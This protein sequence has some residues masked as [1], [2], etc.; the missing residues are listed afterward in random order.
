MTIIGKQSIGLGGVLFLAAIGLAACTGSGIKETFSLAWSDSKGGVHVQYSEDGAAW[1]NAA[2]P[3][4]FKTVVGVGVAADPVGAEYLLIGQAQNG[5]RVG[6]FSLGP[7]GYMIRPPDVLAN[8]SVGLMDT[9]PAMSSSSLER[10]YLAYRSVENV[11]VAYLERV[12]EGEVGSTKWKN[13][14]KDETPLLNV[15]NTAVQGWPSLSIKGTRVVVSWFRKPAGGTGELQI[16]IGDLQPNGSIKWLGGQVFPNSEPN[17]GGVELEH[18]LCNDGQHFFLGVTR[19]DGGAQVGQYGLY[20]YKSVDG[21]KWTLNQYVGMK[22]PTV[23]ES[24][25]N[26]SPLGI[27]V[28]SKGVIVVAEY[29]GGVSRVWRFDKQWSKSSSKV[30]SGYPASN[31]RFSLISA[32]HS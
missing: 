4:T 12:G 27:A 23:K 9:G 10:W 6:V 28:N 7:D 16:A 17:A 3:S 8:K 31:K 14:W 11:K 21:M 32:A 24:F 20:L 15:N 5:D 19:K 25:H 2:F 30:F 22:T 26:A 29:G 18:D 13:T 1:K